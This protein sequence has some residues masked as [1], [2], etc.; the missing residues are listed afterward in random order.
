MTAMLKRVSSGSSARQPRAISSG[1]VVPH[2]AANVAKYFSI[3]GSG[4]RSMPAGTGVCVVNTPPA[5]TAS[6]AS[7]NVS[8]SPTSSRIRSNELNPAWPSLLWNTCG[9]RPRARRTR[10]PAIPSTISWRMRCSGS[11][12]YKPVGDRVPVGAVAVDRGV[13]EVQRHPPDLG[14][15]RTDLDGVAGDVDLDDHIRRV[16]RQP[17]GVEAG[18]ALLLVAVGVEPLTEVALGV[19]QADADERDAEIRRR[20]EVIA[21]EDAE[22]ARVL[23]Q[24]LAEAELRREVG[25]ESEWGVADGPGT[26][27]ATRSCR[28]ADRPRRGSTRRSTGRRRA[29]PSGRR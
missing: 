25:D 29:V 27:A 4:N 6:I 20:L 16:Q 15:P 19:Q 7:W 13:E 18:E 22:A 21:G 9:S 8:P 23:R 28:A 26:T 12:P 2:S 10:T 14:L 3:I 24:R 5:R 1:N 17:G 11:P